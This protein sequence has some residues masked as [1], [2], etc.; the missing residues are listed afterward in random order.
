M[1]TAPL[2]PVNR[3]SIC[4][5]VR[6][7]NSYDRGT[8]AVAC[9]SELYLH[10]RWHFQCRYAVGGDEKEIPPTFLPGP[11]AWRWSG[12]RAAGRGRSPGW[13]REALPLW[14]CHRNTPRRC[15]PTWWTRWLLLQKTHPQRFKPKTCTQTAVHIQLCNRAGTK[16]NSFFHSLVS[17]LACVVEWMQGSLFLG[18][19]GNFT[20]DIFKAA[21]WLL[22]QRKQKSQDIDQV[23]KISK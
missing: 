20:R 9:V 13:G 6:S 2:F 10:H 19:S 12:R 1:T 14:C 8:E 4:L 23:T 3:E 15:Y 7:V 22:L 11:W 17:L 5:C 16:Q 18:F 21:D